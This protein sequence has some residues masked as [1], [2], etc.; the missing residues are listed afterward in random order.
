MHLLRATCALVCASLALAAPAER[1]PYAGTKVYRIPTGNQQQ[2]DQIASMVT[3]LGVP[4]WK[5]AKI[6]FSHI[7][8]EVSKDQLTSFHN[9]LKQINPQLESQLI[10]MHEDLGVSIAKE[11]EGMN[12]PY[13]DALVGY[14]NAA[15]FNS[16]HTYA[17]HLTFLKD[18]ASTFPDNAKVITGGTSYEGR[19]ITGINIFG[20]SELNRIRDKARDYFP[21]NRSRSR[22]DYYD[23][24]LIALLSNYTTSPTIKSYVDKYDFYIFPI[25]NPD[26]FVYTQTTERLW[27]K[28]RQPPPSGTCYGRDINRNWPW[29]W[30]VAG[31]SSTSPCSETYRGAAAGDSPE[32][33]GLAAFINEKANSAVGAKLYIDWHSY[34]L[35]FMG[36]YGYSCSENAADKAEHTRI[37]QGFAAAFRAPYGKSLKTG[38]ICSTIY[39]VSG[40]SVDYTYDVS[41][42]KYSFTPELRGGSSGSGFILPPAEILPSG[43]EAYEGVKY[44]L[45]N[46]I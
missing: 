19:P 41:K 23:G 24:E 44:L 5:S 6:A 39:Q 46:M 38:P 40:G 22:V 3:T 4:T 10:T 26:G 34:G 30:D 35:Y 31:G 29:K 36:P 2:T 20:S 16:Y 43:I 37:E 9:A 45:A 11:A 7:D 18:L 15:W 27:R 1:N 12:S 21:W 42:I 32:N 25:V 14:A 33:K 13:R 17:D 8:V 28:N